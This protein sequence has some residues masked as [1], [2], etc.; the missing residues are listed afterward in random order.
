MRKQGRVQARQQREAGYSESGEA[1]QGIFYL[2]LVPLEV[3][4]ED[5][6]VRGIWVLKNNPV[7]FGLLVKN[8][9]HPLEGR[10]ERQDRISHH[11]W[12]D[13]TDGAREALWLLQEGQPRSSG[14]VYPDCPVVQDLL[15]GVQ[16]GSLLRHHR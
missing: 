6:A 7:G 13:S 9:V 3:G 16:R 15:S 1:Q 8:V 4:D 14:D 2:L 12:G 11:P 5:K 10:G